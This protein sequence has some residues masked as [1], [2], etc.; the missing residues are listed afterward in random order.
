MSTEQH[1]RYATRRGW[2][3]PDPANV[4]IRLATLND[5]PGLTTLFDAYRMFYGFA[6]GHRAAGEFLAARLSRH[7]STILVAVR[8]PN[9][10][11]VGF[12]Q[13]FPGFSS[14]SLGAVIVLNDLFVIPSARQHG[15]GGRLVDAA[16]EYA[17]QSGAIRV[18]LETHPENS[19]AMELYRDKGFVPD[20][21]FM[22]MSRSL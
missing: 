21:E 2:A 13:L 20:I 9:E 16:V 18:D 17:R 19:A 10:E 1:A 12:A 3:A 8:R 22:H 5:L 15:V 6:S 11:L 14:L 4:T 7:E